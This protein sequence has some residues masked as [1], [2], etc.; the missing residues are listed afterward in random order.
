MSKMKKECNWCPNFYWVGSQREQKTTFHC[1]LKPQYFLDRYT[2]EPKWCPL[3][4]DAPKE[5]NE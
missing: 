2:K 5:D 1:K 4:K 3:R